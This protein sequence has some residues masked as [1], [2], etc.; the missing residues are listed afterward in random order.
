MSSG[1]LVPAPIDP[2]QYGWT[3]QSV[4]SDARKPALPFGIRRMVADMA[5]MT[6]SFCREGPELLR[7]LEIEGVIS[8]QAESAGALVAEHLELPF[9]TIAAALPLNREPTVP[10][11]VLDW[12]YDA[13]EKG[14]RRNRGGERVADWL[15]RPLDRT[16]KEE[17]ARLGCMPKR[18]QTDCLSPLAEIAQLAPGLDFPRQELPDHVHY[19]GPLRGLRHIAE[20]TS[21]LLAIAPDR[22]FVFASLGTLQGHRIAVFRRIARA[23]RGLGAQL[24][25]AHCGGLSRREA[26]SIGADWVVDRVDQAQAVARADVVVTHAGLNTVLDALQAGKPLLCL[27]LAFD[28]PGVA[29]RVAR[30]GAGEMLKPWS[31]A[32]RIKEALARLLRSELPR[33][34]ARSLQDEFAQAG[35]AA[36]AAMIAEQALLSRRPVARQALRAAE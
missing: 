23:C 29:A 25:V 17:A 20:N 5:A 18:N 19:V 7:C 28:Q 33:E 27:P 12:P 35:G 16:I 21:P 9:V 2:A 3:P 34:R 31:S 32:S 30:L 1:A 11:P 24:L 6:K 15:M 36:R 26:A 10:L 13:S 4:I 22:P 14:V 8:D